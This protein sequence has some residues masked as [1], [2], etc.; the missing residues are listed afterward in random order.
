MDFAAYTSTVAQ[1]N[2][3]RRVKCACHL[4]Q[5]CSS[6][7]RLCYSHP[8]SKLPDSW[9]THPFTDKGPPPWA[10]GKHLNAN[11]GKSP[12][13]NALRTCI[14]WMVFAVTSDLPPLVYHRPPKIELRT[15]PIRYSSPASMFLCIAFLPLRLLLVTPTVFAAG[16]PQE[17]WIVATS[18]LYPLQRPILVQGHCGDPQGPECSMKPD[19]DTSEPQC[20]PTPAPPNLYT[21]AH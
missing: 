11:I 17:E 9:V 21:T 6:L 8:T 16:S 18:L 20:L 5:F 1:P 7:R 14:A 13:F 19:C 10:L 4:G 15:L 2:Q 12:S 3:T